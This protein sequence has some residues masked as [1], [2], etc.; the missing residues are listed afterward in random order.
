MDV[1]LIKEPEMEPL[2]SG[3]RLIFTDV[4]LRRLTG[5]VRC[6]AQDDIFYVVESNR[7][8]HLISVYDVVAVIG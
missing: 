1:C 6:K 2:Q 4:L 7:G 3:T 8:T 5:Q